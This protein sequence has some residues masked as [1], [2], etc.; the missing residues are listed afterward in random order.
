[1]TRFVR[2][3]C[4]MLALVTVV[5]L[6]ACAEPT[7]PETPDNGT[8][9][10]PV[11]NPNTDLPPENNGDNGENNNNNE[12][13]GT[14]GENETP[15]PEPEN[16]MITAANIKKAKIVYI[17]KNYASGGKV[18]QA[19]DGLIALIN[20]RYSCKM[21]KT[22]DQ[23]LP[24][25]PDYQEYEYEIIIGETKRA[26]S[27]NK[28][29]DLLYSDWGYVIDGTKIVIKGGSQEALLEA[30]KSFKAAISATKENPNVFYDR[31]MDKIHR[32]NLAGKDLVINGTP[33]SEFSI[34]YPAKGSEYEEALARRLSDYIASISGHV[35][36]F[37]PDSRTKGA[38]EIL[39]GKT[40]RAF[41]VLTQSGAALETDQNHIAIVGENAYDYGLAQQALSNLLLSAAL[42][43]TPVTLPDKTPVEDTEKVKVMSYNVYGFDYY[44]SRC[45]NMRRLITKYLPDIIGYQEPD[46][47]MTDKLRMEGYY[48]WFDGEARH[49]YPNGSLVSDPSGANSISPIGYAKDRYTFILGDTKWS[50]G[51]PD[52]PSK[53]PASAYYRMYT[54]VMLLDN[55]T[56]EELIVVNHHLQ[57]QVATEQVTYMFKFFQEN[58]TDVPVIMLGDFNSESNTDVIKRVVMQEGGFTSLHKMATNPEAKE[59]RID[60]IFGMSCCIQGTFFKVCYETYPDSQA[61]LDKEYGDGKIPSDHEPVYGEFYI[62][63]DRA[64]HTHDW[65]SLADDYDWVTKPT[66][67]ER[68]K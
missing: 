65:S 31:S 26:A 18:E 67:P 57:R 46:V 16:V 53:N 40:N 28:L 8:Q 63:S 5:G 15:D 33:I 37:I 44:A 30:I 24:T 32:A 20:S 29:T 35:L 54:Y 49:T 47:T 58:Y 7:V 9:T 59:P 14:G 11:D 2:Y 64:D 62:K 60:W 6:C 21:I 23:V 19:L 51:T 13:P 66:V 17:P 48:E 38:H 39:I 25:N 12:N 1:M 10:P 3:L 68:Q 50:T 4:L 36:Q 61:K 42:A 43:K 34:V 52:V 22:S 41:T 27:K 45:D 56:G 55:V